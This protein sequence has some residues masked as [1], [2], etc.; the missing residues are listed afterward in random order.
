MKK[1]STPR[2]DYSTYV[3]QLKEAGFTITERSG[4]QILVSKYGCGIVMEKDPA[5]GP[6]FPGAPGFMI[7]EAI[8]PLL[9]GGYQKFWQVDGR[10]LPALAEQLKALHQFENDFRGVMGVTSL[11]NQSLGTVSARYVYDRVEGREGQKIHHSFD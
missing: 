10:R 9:D 5:G 4:G 11:Y 7:G 1:V 8:A 6:R 3:Q 2:P